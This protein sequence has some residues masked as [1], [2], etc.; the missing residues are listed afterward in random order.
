MDTKAVAQLAGQLISN[1]DVLAAF[2][3]KLGGMVGHCSG[4]IS[5]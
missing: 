2:S 1:P 3:Q 4:Y 5:R